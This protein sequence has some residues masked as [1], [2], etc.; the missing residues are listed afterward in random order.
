MNN[1]NYRV[2]TVLTRSLRY[3]LSETKIIRV[4]RPFCMMC[5]RAAHH[6]ALMR[7][8]YT[9]TP[10]VLI[11]HRDLFSIPSPLNKTKEYAE[12]RIIGY[13]MQ[14][15]YEVVANVEDYKEFVPWC[16]QS[17]IVQRKA[18]HFKAQLEIGFNPLVE[19]YMSTVTLVKPHLVKAVCT[20]GRLFNHLITMWRFSPGIRGKPDTCT[21]DFAI[22]FEFRSVLHSNLSAL[23]FDEV[24]KKMVKAFEKRAEKLYGPQAAKKPAP[25]YSI[26]KDL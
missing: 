18:G 6:Q 4:N 19:R 25:D 10:L 20:D 11:P 12:R 9:K 23:F 13:S 14:D 16:T 1:T 8:N 21:I 24:V 26:V 7:V 5:V 2:A 15:M 17:K 3:V 22:S